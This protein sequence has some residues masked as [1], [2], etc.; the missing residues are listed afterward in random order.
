MVNIHEVSQAWVA[1]YFLE[2]P[3]TEGVGW[4]YGNRDGY[5]C[6][7]GVLLRDGDPVGRFTVT[8]IRE[9]ESYVI[10]N[11]RNMPDRG[12]ELRHYNTG[13]LGSESNPPDTVR[14]GE[15]PPPTE[16]YEE[17]TLP[18]QFP[19]IDYLGPNG[20]LLERR[21]YRRL[22]NA[23]LD[24]RLKF[25]LHHADELRATVIAYWENIPFAVV[26]YDAPYGTGVTMSAFVP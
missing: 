1:E 8:A 26:Y 5:K 13:L 3:Y 11:D 14:Q 15:C 20:E 16:V 9:A 10:I 18:G 17:S 6:M 24:P 23:D 22:D 7:Y 4:G 25:R 19:V 21:D 2:L 12:P